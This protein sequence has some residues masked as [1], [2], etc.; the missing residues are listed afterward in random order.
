VGRA[1]VADHEVSD[2]SRA[3]TVSEHRLGTRRKR[4]G[5]SGGLRGVRITRCLTPREGTPR[6]QTPR[7]H[8]PRAPAP[9]SGREMLRS[10]YLARP[11]PRWSTRS[12]RHDVWPLAR[13]PRAPAP[14][15][16]HAPDQRTRVSACRM[17]ETRRIPGTCDRGRCRAGCRTSRYALARHAPAQSEAPGEVKSARAEYL[18]IP[19]NSAPR[20]AV[21]A[22]GARRHFAPVG[23]LARDLM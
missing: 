1:P 10:S 13:A 7:E 22:I 6:E 2:T 9:L 14:R 18:K 16:L 8:R 5:P 21:R 17:P 3:G 20:A 19:R 15:L 23:S 11:E 12:A 4:R